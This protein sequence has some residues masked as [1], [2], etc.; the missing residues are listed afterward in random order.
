MRKKI[1]QLSLVVALSAGLVA[2]GG[3]KA[4][5]ASSTPETTTT[6][7]ETTST[8][9]PTTP[10]EEETP[11]EEP[12]TLVADMEVSLSAVGESMPEMAYEPAVITAE[13]YVNLQLN[14]NNASTAEGMNHNA[15]IIKKD[16]A[17]AD[18]IRKAGGAAG[19]PNFDPVDDRIIGKTKMLLPGENTSVVFETPG[20]GEYYIICTFPGHQAMVGT[21]MV[22]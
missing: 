17:L 7:E 19:G 12:E 9:E 2:C 21:L 22:E 13:A 4:P 18:E 5:E 16:D 8:P 1:F 6:P 15:V 20:P 11:A 3:E 14:F 10:V